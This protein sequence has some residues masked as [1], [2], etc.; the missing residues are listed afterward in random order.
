MA[1]QQGSIL[2]Y[3]VYFDE[4]IIDLPNAR[5]EELVHAY[6]YGLKLY[7]KGHIKS[8]VQQNSLMKLIQIMMFSLQFEDAMKSELPSVTNHASQKISGQHFSGNQGNSSNRPVP[9]ELGH[10]KPQDK[11]R[12]NLSK[13]YY[14]TVAKQA[15]TQGIVHR[16]SVA[17][18]VTLTPREVSRIVRTS[19]S[20]KLSQHLSEVRS[21]LHNAKGTL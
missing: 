5:K 13:E 8:H 11:Y 16:R 1:Q 14:T 4:I 6:I 15:I 2:L 18:L 3:I 9:M 10:M 21:M 20:K 19:L 7:I 17:S 12:R